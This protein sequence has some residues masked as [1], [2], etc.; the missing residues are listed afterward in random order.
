LDR[1]AMEIHLSELRGAASQQRL[2]SAAVSLLS[3]AIM[4]LPGLSKT[5]S[6]LPAAHYEFSYYRGLF[7]WVRSRFLLRG[8]VTAL[9]YAAAL[10]S[11]ILGAFVIWWVAAGKAAQERDLERW[12]DFLSS[13]LTEQDTVVLADFKNTTGDPAFDE[14]L[15]QR[16]DTRLDQLSFLKPEALQASKL[17]LKPQ[18]LQAYSLGLRTMATK[19]DEAAIPF[20][21]Q[22]TARDPNFA[23][24][25]ARLA[26]VYS[27]LN[28]HSKSRASAKKAYELRDRVTKL[29]WFYIVSHYYQNVTGELEKAVDE[30]QRWQQTYPR[31]P[32]PFDDLGDIYDEEGRYDEALKQ[33]EEANGLDP[34][35]VG[36]CTDLVAAYLQ[37]NRLDDAREALKEAQDAKLDSFQLRL[38]LYWVAFLS[39]DA[40]G[41]EQQVKAAMGKPEMKDRL[42][43][44]KA[45]T[46]AYHGRLASAREFTRRALESADPETA[47]GYR[48][49]GALREAEFGNTQQ[50]KSEAVAALSLAPGP[51]V[52]TLG[53]LALAR[54]GDA[55]QALA[56]AEEL[57]RQSPLDTLLNKYWLP[58]IRAAAAEAG[59][60]RENPGAAERNA[61]K[62]IELLQPLIPY[63]DLGTP[64][65]PTNNLFL[66]P[67]YLRGQAYLALRQGRQAATEFQKILD[68]PGA[69][70]NSAL[71]ALAHV[72]L[73]R[74]RALAGDIAGARAAYQDFL[75]LWK[76]ADPDVPILKQAK[77]EYAKLQP[78]TK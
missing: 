32:T 4:V 73:G 68:H 13:R 6:Y 29:E 27:D 59:A 54:A 5:L 34:H 1:D 62:A 3:A 9:G 21:Q 67:P 18:A 15:K 11:C 60:S 65:T 41:M 42:L 17:G 72:G 75:A 33:F 53:A 48:T 66:Y 57:N 70:L 25:Y 7:S 64:M 19:G 43:A 40:E 22:A 45:D 24:A 56:I 49:V 30:Y 76:D 44:T 38:D 63:Y 12:N 2:E 51:V 31:D 23:M 28:Q 35:F 20:F 16:V 55:G 37:L 69:V 71:A 36:I 14:P 47:A 39:G 52:R 8:R 26:T 50:A 77:I 10:A 61:S 78:R 46:E 58:T 74:A